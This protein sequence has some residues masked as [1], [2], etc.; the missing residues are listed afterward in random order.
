MNYIEGA[1][2]NKHRYLTLVPAVDFCL[3]DPYFSWSQ[4]PNTPISASINDELSQAA[5][6]TR[7]TMAI[8][9]SWIGK[10]GRGGFP[11]CPVT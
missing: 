5:P 9:Q 8:A 10:D 7:H 1:Y 11:L 2:D 3:W 4:A 6:E